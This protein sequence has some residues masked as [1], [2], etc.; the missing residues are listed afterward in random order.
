MISKQYIFLNIKKR[1]DFF[2]VIQ[3][4]EVQL[5]PEKFKLKQ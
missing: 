5:V 1:N 4:I 3:K 2:I